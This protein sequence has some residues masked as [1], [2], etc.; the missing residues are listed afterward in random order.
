VYLQL[1]HVQLDELR[2]RLRRRTA[3]LWLWLVVDPCSKIIPVLPV[4]Y[5]RTSAAASTSA[6]PFELPTVSDTVGEMDHPR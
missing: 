5:R 3:V 2:T 4:A 1:S 6:S